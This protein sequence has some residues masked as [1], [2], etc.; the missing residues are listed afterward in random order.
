VSTYDRHPG[1]GPV[2]RAAAGG[3]A[4]ATGK[5]TLTGQLDPNVP[6]RSTPHAAPAHQV[7]E[8]DALNCWI[9]VIVRGPDGAEVARWRA[10][11]RWIGP[12]PVRYH[13]TRAPLGWTWSD[14]AARFTRI[15]TLADGTGGEPVERWAT[16]HGAA[17]VDVIATGLDD[18]AEP[19]VDQG[20]ARAGTTPGPG[21][22][23]GDPA[24]PGPASGPRPRPAHEQ[25]LAA[26]W[27]E[28]DASDAAADQAAE[29]G[30]G[31]RGAPGGDPH[32]RPGPTRRS[33]APG[34]AVPRRA[35]A[36]TTRAPRPAA[37]PRGPGSARCSAWRTAPRADGS[38][39]RASRVTTASA[40]PAR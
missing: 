10:R 9:T 5:H 40:W 7:A 34:R 25:L 20:R 13:G 4:P 31:G 6:L 24:A 12:L 37:R 38:A 19:S 28:V 21:S 17:T 22:T 8:R 27:R 23:S 2:Q 3:A 32:G 29:D 26:F 11:G 1:T 35:S 14:P 16:A 39:A 36:A 33:A 30:A 18:A 15:H